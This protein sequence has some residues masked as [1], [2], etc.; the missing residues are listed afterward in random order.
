MVKSSILPENNDRVYSQVSDSELSE[1]PNERIS[2]RAIPYRANSKRAIKN[3]IVGFFRLH[4]PRE[5]K[6]REHAIMK[7]LKP[8][9]HLPYIVS[10][11]LFSFGR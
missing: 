1:F 4:H 9:N 8:N 5:E 2:N 10:H 11:N 7:R 3:N 6:I